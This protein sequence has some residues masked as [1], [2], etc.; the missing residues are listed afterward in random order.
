MTDS[1]DTQ[2][3]I[4]GRFDFKVPSPHELEAFSPDPVPMANF[5]EQADLPSTTTYMNAY[6]FHRT[7]G[8]ALEKPDGTGLYFIN[9]QQVETPD[10]TADFNLLGVEADGTQNWMSAGGGRTVV[11][12]PDGT[13]VFYQDYD[14]H[15]EGG[16]AYIGADGSEA[17]FSGGTQIPGPWPADPILSEDTRAD[18]KTREG[19]RYVEGRP[20]AEIAAAIR[21][22]VALALRAGTLDRLGLKYTVRVAPNRREDRPTIKVTVTGMPAWRIV[23]E[24]EPYDQPFH[25]DEALAIT[26][27]LERI[28]QAYNKTTV[29]NGT[30]SIKSPFWFDTTITT[31]K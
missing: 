10:E 23:R 31:A 1:S 17:W 21:E 28:G 22:D 7:N 2:P 6:G 18:T 25:S 27:T 3:R 4:V 24:G 19:S 8:F 11:V 16:P 13:K 26:E 29:H 20:A 12:R 14:V 9:G 30:D 5:T 15:R